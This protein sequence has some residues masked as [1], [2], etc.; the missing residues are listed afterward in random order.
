MRAAQPG[1]SNTVCQF[2]LSACVVANDSLRLQP[3]HVVVGNNTLLAA[4]AWF[5]G[6]HFASYGSA[7]ALVQM[8]V[9]SCLFHVARVVVF[10]VIKL[11]SYTALA[12]PLNFRPEEERHTTLE[13]VC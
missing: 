2:V 10:V 13:Q 6:C 11:T 7:G 8:T 9:L 12:K 4:A 3:P 1:G 5:A